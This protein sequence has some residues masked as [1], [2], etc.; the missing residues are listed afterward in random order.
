MTEQ[1]KVGDLIKTGRGTVITVRELTEKHELIPDGWPIDKHGNAHN[2]TLCSHYK[3][4]L[5]VLE[6]IL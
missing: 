3:G 1:L 5:S 4:A 2:P 6:G